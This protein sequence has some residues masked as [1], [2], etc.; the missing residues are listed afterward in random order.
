MQGG[1]VTRATKVRKGT[2]T[3]KKREGAGRV[4]GVLEERVH[5]CV[6]INLGVWIVDR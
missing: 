2:T 5:A 3:R 4:R 1:W 6:G